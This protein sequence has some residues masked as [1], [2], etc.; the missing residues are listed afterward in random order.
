VVRRGGEG[1]H[2][3]LANGRTVVFLVGR[4]R[5]ARA[6]DSEE[7]YFWVARSCSDPGDRAPNPGEKARQS[8]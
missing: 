1:V 7:K 2:V 6:V 4:G 3:H 5:V 8:L